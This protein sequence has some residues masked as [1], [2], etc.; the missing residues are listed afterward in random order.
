MQRVVISGGSGL[1]GGL[2]SS[3]LGRDNFDVVHLSHRKGRKTGYHT[4]LWDPA[5]GYCDSEAFHDGD[6]IIHLAGA[7]IGGRRWTGDRKREIV[8]SR[9]KTAKLLYEYSVGAGIIPSVFVTASAT[10]IYGSSITENVF[11]ESDPPAD[12]FLGETC[13]LWEAGA[14]P[15][16]AAGVRVVIIRTAPVLAPTG[17]VLSK[18]TAAAKAG[19]IVRVAPGNQYFPWIHINDLCRIYVKSVSDTDMSGP[20]N[21]SAPDHITHD[22]FMSEVARQKR[23]P[24]FLPHVPVWLMRV[25]LGE[26]SVVLT[27]GS[28]ISS[29]RLEDAG[30][31]F[32]YPDIKS[33]LGAC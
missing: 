24:V 3:M 23:L 15:F 22:M 10:G 27:T 1:V 26:M 4:Y 28:R 2:L 5:K 30:F 29:R 31:G 6:A 12:D 9:T 16:R 25:V 11:E 32:S 33:A 17:S 18:M 8:D 14:E 13:R 20:Y 19:L 21:A 7:N